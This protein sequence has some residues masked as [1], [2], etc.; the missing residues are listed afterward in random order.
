MDLVWVLVGGE[1]EAEFA[2]GG[3]GDDGLGAVA[4]VSAEEA[5][6]VEAGSR[7]SS[8]E[9][10]EAG[11]A[12][13]GVHAGV[14]DP[15]GFIEV[16]SSPLVAFG[17]GQGQDVIVEAIDGDVMVS[18]EELAEDFGQFVGGV[19]DGSAVDAGV[20]VVVGSVQFDFEIKHAPECVGDGGG[21]FV[22]HGGVGDEGDV[23]FE[24]V[25]VLVDEAFELAG[26]AL[27]FAFDEGDD[28]ERQRAAGVVPGAERFE[29]AGDLPFVVDG[30]AG[31][32]FVFA[33]GGLKCGGGPEVDGVGGL[34]VVV[35][36]EQDGGCVGDVGR[37]GEDDGVGVGLDQVG[38]EAG[39]G[40]AVG[41]PPG[42]GGA[43]AGVGGVGAD[44][45][46]GEPLDGAVDGVVAIGSQ[47]FEDIIGHG[48]AMIMGWAEIATVADAGRVVGYNRRV[49]RNGVDLKRLELR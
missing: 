25:G 6:D 3:C 23:G 4:L 46:D 37:A 9:G 1:P 41:G 47:Y 34:D 49:G 30:A 45:G 2:A 21:V 42:G 20:Q 28:V 5:V 48:W 29:E 43:I 27:F 44:R 11:L 15:L 35:A 17:V 14:G 39:F 26:A 22:P 31:E 40:E 7:P 33:D 36:V 18:I 8:F 38:G 19:G 16:Q 32:D 12:V 24:L 10:G 13:G